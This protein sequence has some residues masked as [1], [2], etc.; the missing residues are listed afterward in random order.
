LARIKRNRIV[1]WVGTVILTGGCCA[2]ALST[3]KLLDGNLEMRR[4]P[5]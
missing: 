5:W 2:S 4:V 3:A 1:I